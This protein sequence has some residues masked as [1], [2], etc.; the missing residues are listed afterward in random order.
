MRVGLKLTTAVQRASK[1]RLSA[2]EGKSR[3]VVA[4]QFNCEVQHRAPK[5]GGAFLISVERLGGWTKW[6]WIFDSALWI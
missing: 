6:R 3:A 5:G 1:G 4:L 2:V